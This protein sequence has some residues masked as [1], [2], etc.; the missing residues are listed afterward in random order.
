[1]PP[2]RGTPNPIEGP[3]DYDTT[4]VVHDDTYAAIDPSKV[5]FSGKAVFISGASRGLGRAMCISFAKA[6]ASMIAVGARSDLSATVKEMKAEAAKAGRSE[7]NILPLKSDVSDRQSIDDAAAQIKKSFGR[8]DIII[9]NAGIFGSGLIADSDPDEWSKVWQVNLVGPY[10]VARAFI[11]LM[12]EGGDK[13]IITVSSV[14]AH[15]ISPGLSAYQSSKLAVLRLSEFISV[16][17][18][19]KGILAYCIHPGNIP[20]DMIG[21]PDG[22]T[23]ELR[24]GKI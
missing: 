6:G 22:L 15:C 9:N 16:E 4:T 23:P 10:L 12:L 19:D 14:G 24:P 18:G 17:Y 8:L 3:G 13:S 20:T 7:P 2:P 5:D 21:G 1:M 11:P